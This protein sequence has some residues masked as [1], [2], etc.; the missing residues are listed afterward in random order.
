[1]TDLV[2]YVR[3]E[4]KLR[5]RRLE[6]APFEIGQYLSPA[7]S[8]NTAWD[9][10]LLVDRLFGNSIPGTDMRNRKQMG[11]R[12]QVKKRGHLIGLPHFATRVQSKTYKMVFRTVCPLQLPSCHPLQDGVAGRQ[13]G[14]YLHQKASSPLDCRRSLL[15]LTLSVGHEHK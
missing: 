12:R 9:K 10:G 5:V 1:M 3:K 2:S 6:G 4:V 13:T 8:S 11:K 7:S 15:W 14:Y